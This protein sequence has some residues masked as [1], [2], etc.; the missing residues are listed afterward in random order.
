MRSLRTLLLSAGAM[1]VVAGVLVVGVG[2]AGASSAGRADSGTA[3]VA[4]TP[5]PG[6]LVYA[7]GFNHD[8]ILGNGAVLYEITATGGKPGVFH[9]TTNHVTMYTAAGSL[10]GTATAT[11]TQKASGGAVI[12][13]GKLKL[14]KG[15]GTLKGH[16]LIATFTGTGSLSSLAFIFKYRG[17]YN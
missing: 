14:T 13:A 1:L 2:G 3:W 9:L 7:A 10:S 12:S 5:K 16:S 15:A 6:T 4:N 17:T 11:L 8:A